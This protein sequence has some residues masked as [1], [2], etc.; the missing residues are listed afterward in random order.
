MEKAAPGKLFLVPA[1]LGEDVLFTLPEYVRDMAIKIR[2]WVVEDVRTTRR[3]LKAID[4]SVDIDNMRFWEWD[5][6]QKDVPRLHELFDL[7]KAGHDIGLMSEAGCPG[8]ADPGSIV[9]RRA[10]ELGIAVVPMVGPNAILLALMASGLNGQYFAFRGYLPIEPATRRS[11]LR[12]LEL[13]M[14]KTS[15]TQL[16]I[17]TPYRNNPLLADM[18]STLHP[19]TLLCI[20][21][22][23][24][25]PNEMV[26]T[27]QVKGWKK[28][29]PDLHKQPCIFAIGK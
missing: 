27:L 12:D 14:Q 4:K 5:K 6:H 1:P 29:T 20:A 8:V 28:N 26:R 22:N 2:Y 17:E 10:H 23:L 18:L 25:T 24:T 16:F 11:R 13:E 3:L 19:D 15:Q 7:A 9:V 21:A